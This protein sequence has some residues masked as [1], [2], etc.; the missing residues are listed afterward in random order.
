[1][2][3]ENM[4]FPIGQFIKPNV[5]DQA[6]INLWIATLDCFP[7]LL[8]AETKQ[9]S[10]DMLNLT[11]RPNGWTIRQVVHHLADSHLNSFMRLKL[12]LTENEPTIKPYF[13]ERWA[14]L[15]DSKNMPIE[16]SLKIIEGVHQRWVA[17]LR[18][19]SADALKRTFFHPEHQKFFSIEENIGVYSWH[20]QHHLAHIQLAKNSL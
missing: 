10:D 17:L 15:E 20:S 7:D 5:I 13:E 3:I 18:T 2:G 9:L 19:I 8:I 12:S 11:Y 4:K 16:P 14:E 6:Q 1:M